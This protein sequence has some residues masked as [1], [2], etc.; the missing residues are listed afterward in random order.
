[1]RDN[2]F[3]IIRYLSIIV[4][5]VI[6][7]LLFWLLADNTEIFRYQDQP[8]N[9][10]R[11]ATLIYNGFLILLLYL[12]ESFNVGKRRLMDLFFGF[13]VA[14]VI[15]NGMFFLIMITLVPSLNELAAALC[16]NLAADQM[17]IGIVWIMT[18][19]RVFEKY[20]FRKKAIFIYGNREDPE[21]VI[22]INKTINKYF[23]ITKSMKYT[24]DA[25]VLKNAINKGNILYIGDIP[26]EA[27][28][29][30]IKYCMSLNVEC[31]SIPKVSDIYINSGKV[32]QLNDK[33]LIQ[34]PQIGISGHKLVLKRLTD[35]VI[36]LAMLIVASPVMLV[37][38]ILVKAEDKGPVFYFQDRVT[39]D[40]RDFRMM[41]F[42]S[43]RVSAED[44]GPRLTSADDDRVTKVGRVIRKIHFDELPQLIN[45]LKGDM[46][47]VGPRPERREF[48]EYYSD[49]EPEFAERLKVKGGLTGM[50]QVYGRYNTEPED[51]IKYDLYYIYHYSLGLDFKL[52]LLTL[53]ILF[54]RENTEG[55]DE[56][57]A[58]ALIAGEEGSEDEN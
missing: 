22:R 30:I 12:L 4:L 29:R 44:E 33:L 8:R 2:K 34:Y 48:I 5:S 32:A 13:G 7:C 41:K 49:K 20:H 56:E 53:R 38:A 16:L 57:Q 25:T 11:G 51:K 43:M 9:M 23:R 35:I 46:S 42:R 47:I 58:Q 37:I 45:I 19:H 14:S 31:Y 55:F 27:R 54:Q 52:I 10:L 40:G 6:Y 36:S 28:N 3:D 17:V 24:N 15:T 18:L 26:A 21:E 1:M 50:A 39:K